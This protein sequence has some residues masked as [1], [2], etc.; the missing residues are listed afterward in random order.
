MGFFVENTACRYWVS[1]AVI[2]PCKKYRYTLSRQWKPAPNRT[3]TF[4]LLNPSRADQT[5]DDPTVRRCIGFA[6]RFECTKLEIVNLFAYRTHSPKELLGLPTKID[7]RGPDNEKWV[8][9]T[10]GVSDVL[11][12]GWGTHGSFRDQDKE[13]LSWIP[14]ERPLFCLGLTKDGYPKHPL[15]LSADRMLIPFPR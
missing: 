9:R 1:G 15:Y 12:C 4:I 3:C 5:E 2:S 14:K 10:E 8:R 13:V 11:I 6:R 7:P